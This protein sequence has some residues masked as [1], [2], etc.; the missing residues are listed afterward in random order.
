M[1]DDENC[2]RAWDGTAPVPVGAVAD[3]DDGGSG[4]AV[5]RGCSNRD[6]RAE[7]GKMRRGDG[8]DDREGD[9]TDGWD[10]AALA[11]CVLGRAMGPNRKE[12][13]LAL[14]KPSS[15]RRGRRGRA[16]R[17]SS[18]SSLPSPLIISSSFPLMSPNMA[19]TLVLV[20]S[21]AKRR[22]SADASSATSREPARERGAVPLSAAT[23]RACETNDSRNPS[24]R[25]ASVRRRRRRQRR[26]DPPL[27]SID[28]SHP[29]AAS[30]TQGPRKPMQSDKRMSR[31]HGASMGI[32]ALRMARNRSASSVTATK[33]GP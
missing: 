27:S 15:S 19:L 21:R 12:R 17:S 23:P 11:V 1:D 8:M 10:G 16:S 6:L 32:P 25:S 28:S 20:G 31:R 5:G 30:I 13:D 24:T 9:G 22:T 18:P 33:V 2:G 14:V 4:V 29:E 26:F 3:D 7:S